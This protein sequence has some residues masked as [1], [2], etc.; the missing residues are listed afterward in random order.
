MFSA[1]STVKQGV[2]SDKLNKKWQAPEKEFPN[3]QK[4]SDTF[5]NNFDW[6]RSGNTNYCLSEIL[7]AQ[8]IKTL[9][10]T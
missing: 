3:T 1:V 7:E 5:Q 4:L 8:H 2:N 10:G 6:G 9:E